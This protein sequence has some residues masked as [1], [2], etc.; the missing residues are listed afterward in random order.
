MKFFGFEL[1]G[2]QFYNGLKLSSY[3]TK[4]VSL[5]LSLPMFG[6]TTARVMSSWPDSIFNLSNY[7]LHFMV[8]SSKPLKWFPFF[9]SV[10]W[11]KK[12]CIWQC[13]HLTTAQSKAVWSL[14]AI[15]LLAKVVC[16]DKEEKM[17]SESW[18][19]RHI[20]QWG[21]ITK[22]SYD[23]IKHHSSVR[24]NYVRRKKQAFHKCSSNDW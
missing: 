6:F 4:A 9:T 24:S 21:R 16:S 18:S 12:N 3:K 10:F 15:W 7:R 8:L 17:T 19:M 2:G 14:V 1:Q 5:P 23:S 11:K 13:G 20:F 22:W